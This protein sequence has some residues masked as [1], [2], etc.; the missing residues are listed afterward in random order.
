MIDLSYFAG[1]KSIS[2]RSDTMTNTTLE[3]ADFDFLENY[4]KKLVVHKFVPE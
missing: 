3:E 2:A 4:V 1:F